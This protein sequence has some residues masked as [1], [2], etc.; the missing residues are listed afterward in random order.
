MLTELTMT[1]IKNLIGQKGAKM[2]PVILM[3]CDGVMC[4][5]V[6]KYIEVANKVLN[7][8]LKVDQVTEF[9]AAKCLS[10]SNEDH[11]FLKNEMA[12]MRLADK[13][14]PYPEAIEAI[15]EIAK[16][17][18][19]YFLTSPFRK[20][21]TWTFDRTKWLKRYFGTELSKKT[22]FTYHKYLVHG[23][24]F[25]DDCVDNLNKW[26][27]FNSGTPILFAQKY[28]ENDLLNEKITRTSDWNYITNLVK[29]Q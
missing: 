8:D 16:I 17:S 10:L 9:D 14:D 12:K 1:E 25:I 29:I 11:L 20:C 4:N 28:N 27:E 15:K 24:I 7:L 13:L 26:I 21:P 5:Y 6:S 18:N 2:R 3:D 22:I 19:L 23:D